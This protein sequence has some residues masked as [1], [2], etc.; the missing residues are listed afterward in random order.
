MDIQ[1]KYQL[2]Q[3]LLKKLRRQAISLAV[4]LAIL[5]WIFSISLVL[6]LI[7]LVDQLMPLPRICRM[8]MVIAFC[9]FVG[10]QCFQY[11]EPVFRKIPL[12]TVA[13]WV[14]RTYPEQ[15][16]HV[17][18]AIQLYPL[19]QNSSLNYSTDLVDKSVEQ[20]QSFLTQISSDHVFKSK[21]ETVQKQAFHAF[22]LMVC[23]V[24]A[25]LLAPNSLTEFTKAFEQTDQ[26]SLISPKIEIS[27]IKPGNSE[28]QLGESINFSALVN[29]AGTGVRLRYRRL[30]GVWQ[31]QPMTKD[32]LYYQTII[33]HI[34]TPIEYY[35]SQNSTPNS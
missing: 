22:F 18:S 27:Q 16:D 10:H 34:T 6:T 14:G 29:Y 24:I 33:Q 23:L 20:A 35:V 3:A 30:E 15:D 13:F 32:G 4:L 28:I 19:R 21:I 11:F 7:L 1:Q 17:L 31:V 26:T 25:L 8:V 12:A 2:I 9:I 5:K